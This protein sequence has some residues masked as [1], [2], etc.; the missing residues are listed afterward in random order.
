LKEE[1]SLFFEV[2]Y[3]TKTFVAF[4]CNDRV[5]K[6]LWPFRN[7]ATTFEVIE[8]KQTGSNCLCCFGLK[9]SGK[10][11]EDGETKDANM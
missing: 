7:P 11:V 2:H 9:R 6:W 8:V 1:E 4:D 5:N 3:K 10:K